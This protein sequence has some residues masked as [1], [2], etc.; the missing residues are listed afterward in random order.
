MWS[1]L[2]KIKDFLSYKS[3]FFSSFLPSF[4]FFLFFSLSVFLSSLDVSHKVQD[5]VW[6]ITFTFKRPSLRLIRYKIDLILSDQ[7]LGRLKVH[8]KTKKRL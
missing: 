4:F 8:V 1:K 7:S 6:F 2:L 5:L 3:L